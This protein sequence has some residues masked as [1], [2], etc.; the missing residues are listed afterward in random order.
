MQVHMYIHVVLHVNVAIINLSFHFWLLLQIGSMCMTI[1]EYELK[2]HK[3]LLEDLGK[4]KRN[5][6]LIQL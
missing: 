3:T 5:C 2:R 1:V 4:K 6:I